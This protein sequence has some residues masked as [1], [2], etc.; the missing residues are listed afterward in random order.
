M[1]RSEKPKPGGGHYDYSRTPQEGGDQMSFDD[2]DPDV[3]L[4]FERELKDTGVKC[5][6]YYH[7][8]CTQ[9]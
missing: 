2:N 7:P 4:Q 1:P 8:H 5:L 9:R 3:H 6:M